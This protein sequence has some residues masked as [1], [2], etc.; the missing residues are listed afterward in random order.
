MKR[1]SPGLFERYGV[2]LEYM[3]V[4]ADTLDVRPEADVLIEGIAGN[5]E[6][7]VARG[8]LAWSNELSLHLI[9]LKTGRPARSLTRLAPAFQEEVRFINDHLRMRNAR[10]LPTAM[11]PW[12][13]PARESRL[14]PHGCRE[15][16]AA[17]DRIFDCSGHGWTNL[18]ST[19]LNLPFRTAG[20]FKRLHAAIRLL[21]PL[22]PALA[23]SSPFVDGRAAPALDMRLQV[24]RNNCRRIPSITARVVPE[25]MDSPARYRREILQRIYRDLAPHD[26]DKVLREEWSNA[27]GAIARFER[28]TIEVRVLDIQECPAADL[29]ILQFI[30]AVVRALTEG[31]LSPLSRQME[32]ATE[33]L[34]R[35]LLQ[36]IRHGGRA[37]IRDAG[38]ARALGWNRPSAAS[39]SEMWR[40]LLDAVCPGKPAWRGTVERIL[41]EGS[42]SERIL[43]AAGSRPTRRK[44]RSVYG[45]LAD[46]LARGEMF[47]P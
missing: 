18:Q 29:A 3:I 28:N 9:E 38:I 47:L 46:C 43:R 44:L 34:Y 4:D 11:H 5:L 45:T 23:A 17:F 1:R 26:P 14:W 32:P 31:R 36:T 35:L 13:N 21:L 7:D 39:V 25:S 24:Y 10:L 41:E 37:G 2:E 12:M 30:V 20:E 16:Y 6:G 42:L 22:M 27:R 8:A 33:T 19:H 40:H 15:I